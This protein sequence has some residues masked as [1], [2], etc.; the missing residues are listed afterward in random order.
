MVFR[1]REIKSLKCLKFNPCAG[2]VDREVWADPRIHA[3]RDVTATGK[4]RTELNATASPAMHAKRMSFF[5]K[6]N[7]PCAATG[8]P[9]PP[10]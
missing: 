3:R 2:A 5:D 8:K 4:S 7:T 6:T 1:C 10:A 9:S